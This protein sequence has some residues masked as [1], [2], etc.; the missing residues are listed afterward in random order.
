MTPGKEIDQLY[1]TLRQHYATA[2]PTLPSAPTLR[3]AWA[4]TMAQPL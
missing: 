2:E 1:Q 4:M 3:E